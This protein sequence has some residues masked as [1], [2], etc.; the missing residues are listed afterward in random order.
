MSAAVFVD[1]N[2]LLYARDMRDRVKQ[3]VAE[4]LLKDL[5]I[6]QTGRTSVQVLSEYYST[7]TRK[8]DPGLSFDEAWEDVTA[9]FAWDPQPI[10]RDLLNRAR[11]VEAR[12]RLSSRDSM[13]V[14]AAQLQNCS[15]L[16]TE[17]LHHDLVCGTVVVRNPFV[18]GIAEDVPQYALEPRPRSRHRPRGRPRGTQRTAVQRS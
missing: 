10:D 15:L 13:I 1:T 4:A 2:V 5:W 18:A 12:H 9:L 17:D 8:L 3:A 14:A 16:V 6:E 11:E 7:V